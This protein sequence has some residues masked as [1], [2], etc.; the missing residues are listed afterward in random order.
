MLVDAELDSQEPKP[1]RGSVG[2]G[3]SSGNEP[4][5]K[6]KK[7]QSNRGSIGGTQGVAQAQPQTLADTEK[8]VFVDAAAMKQ[9]VRENLTKHKVVV[10]DYYKEEGLFQFVARATWF[11]HIT[12]SVIAINALWI[13]I[14]TDH[15]DAEMLL[16]AHIVFQVAEHLFCAF[17]TFEWT[18]R[19]MSFEKK[20]NCCRDAWFVFDSMLVFTM[21]AETWVMT[22]V[23]TLQTGDGGG[24]MGNA[25]ILR[26]A[27]LL[28]L[29]RM[30]RM[31]RLLRSM[32]ELMVLIKG[33]LAATRSVF[34][35][36]LLLL[37]IMYVF[38]IAFT[39][40]CAGTD[41][42]KLYF[43]S[44]GPAMYSLLVYG[45]LLDD[46][47]NFANKL[48][49]ESYVIAGIFFLFALLAALT[50]MNML[51]GVLCEVVS[52]VA[53]T[54][55]E[56]MLVGYV[57][58]KLRQV[59]D[60]MDADGDCQISKNEFVNIL[61]NME[62]SRALHEVGVDVVGLIDFAEFIFQ[63]E[64]S[65]DA[66]EERALSFGDFM[67]VILQLRGTN[68]ATVKDIVDLRK[69]VRRALI[70]TNTQLASLVKLLTEER[71]AGVSPPSN[72]NHNNCDVS[73]AGSEEY[74]SESI[75]GSEAA[76]ADKPKNQ[77]AM[78][79]QVSIPEKEAAQQIFG[80]VEDGGSPV[81]PQLTPPANL[82]HHRVQEN[83]QLLWGG[84]RGDSRQHDAIALRG[85]W[86][87]ILGNGFEK[88]ANDS[89]GERHVPEFNGRHLITSGHKVDQTGF[90]NGDSHEMVTCCGGYP[91]RE[92][93]DNNDV[94][95]EELRAQMERLG[96]V[97]S[98]GLHEFNKIREALDRDAV[99]L[100]L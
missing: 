55:K 59:V 67:E 15:N 39:Q 63:D 50:V 93:S 54:E 20:K 42:G 32:P 3:N 33:M 89:F 92:L 8:R 12:L 82:L 44:V 73:A 41:V 10:S 64:N 6:R 81:P 2:S 23:Q 30:A 46:V 26:I 72:N 1:A 74:R 49:K 17:F 56:E 86:L 99:R 53:A 91:S 48:G 34:F 96:K 95:P 13:A 62:A 25:S 19:F 78:T 5:A 58:G 29:S 60:L 100:T 68:N 47:S 51:I 85:Q 79:R 84:E 94:D 88:S 77:G 65:T 97:L 7:K 69:F 35:T 21:V 9:K 80:S 18:A 87:P 22:L 14:D 57:N 16:E 61:E 11:E 83:Q 43:S 28:R 71:A 52:A 76:A 37:L 66:E 31:A 98:A 40:L 70:Q 90:R 24:G 45:A 27:R 38:A 36:L 75:F 4:D